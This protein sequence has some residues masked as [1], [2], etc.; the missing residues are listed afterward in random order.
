MQV[1]FIAN[2]S[3][4]LLNLYASL[5]HSSLF[6]PPS[7]VYA[8]PVVDWLEV[9]VYF[10]FFDLLETDWVYAVPCNHSSMEASVVPVPTST[11]GALLVFLDKF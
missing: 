2:S 6:P 8:T 11:F 4:K 1:I 7:P 5:V 3:K 9:L 10:F